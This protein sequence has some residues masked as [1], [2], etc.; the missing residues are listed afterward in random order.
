MERKILVVDDDPTS[1]S[2]VSFILKTNGYAVVV[3]A[4]GEEGLKRADQEKPDLVVLD[5]MM[6]KMDG[7]TFLKQLKNINHLKIPPVIMLTSKEK[8]EELFKVEGVADFF[9]KPL[10]TTKFL[11]RVKELL[12]LLD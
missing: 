4:D 1:N 8:M 5:V 3:A 9:L 11:K 7:Y 12:P 2:L 6:P 10:D